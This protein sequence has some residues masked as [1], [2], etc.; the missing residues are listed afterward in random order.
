MDNEK[1]KKIF[2]ITGEY[3]GSM[4]AQKVVECLKAQDSNLIIEGIGDENLEK[5]GV[6]LFEN[7]SKMS[8]VGLSQK[9]LFNHLLLG[10]RVV[11][12][13]TKVYKPD[14]VLLI[15]YGAFNLNVSKFL[16][17]HNIKTYY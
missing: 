10:K 2:I 3:S 1:F 8:A 17:R 14:L 5:A 11:D 12:Y 13:L 4:H 16:K 7:H 6:K 15:D 9:I